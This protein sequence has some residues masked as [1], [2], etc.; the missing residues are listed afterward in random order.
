M[1]R[2]TSQELIAG[3]REALTQDVLPTAPDGVPARQ[4]KAALHILG[5]LGRT[6][7]DPAARIRADLADIGE[8]LAGL[9]A[10]DAAKIGSDLAG[11]LEQARTVPQ[12]AT[13][14]EQ[15]H[16]RATQALV[17]ADTAV[18]ERPP[19]SERTEHLTRLFELYSR[20]L[21]RQDDA[22]GTGAAQRP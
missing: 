11:D 21:D 2:P 6:A 12:A 10:Q 14:L 9:Q 22:M 5:R 4:L 20:M 8:V 16:R 13:E 19:G 3:I 15:T 17:D 18:R 1:L 7:E